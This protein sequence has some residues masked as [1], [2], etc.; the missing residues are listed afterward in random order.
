MDSVIRR[1]FEQGSPEAV[2]HLKPVRTRLGSA[3]VV[4]LLICLMVAVLLAWTWSRGSEATPFSI[5]FIGTTNHLPRFAGQYGVFAITNRSSFTVMMLPSS[6]WS[7]ENGSS[8]YA[9]LPPIGTNAFGTN[10]F[11]TLKP[12]EGCL[13]RFGEATNTTCRLGIEWIPG[14]A[15]KWFRVPL[16]FRER[17]PGDLKGVRVRYQASEW[18]RDRGLVNETR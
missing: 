2:I 13:L 3:K 14:L 5:T 7:Y 12:R 11:L 16:S 1:A 9:A 17:V 8:S 10:A 4:L 6:T 15:S 18:I